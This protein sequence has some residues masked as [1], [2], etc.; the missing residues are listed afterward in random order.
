MKKNK[1]AA[2]IGCGIS[3]ITTAYILQKQGWEI[4]IIAKDDP[5]TSSLKPEFSSLYP[6][7]SIVPH[8]VFS[9]KIF[10]LFKD[11]LDHFQ[12]LYEQEFPGVQIHE[13]FE[14]FAEENIS[15]PDY[16][17][18]LKNLHTC[19]EFS[20]HFHPQHPDIPIQSGWKFDCFFAD[21]TLYFP[22]LIDLV[23]SKGVE[24]ELRELKAKDL[25]DLPYDIIINCSELGSI[26]L[27]EEKHD[28]IY[29]GHIL[30]IYDTPPLTDPAGKNVSYN[31][32]PGREVYAS[33]SGILQDVYLYPRRDGWVLGGS[34]QRGR[35]DEKGNWIGEETK[36]PFS[37]IDSIKVPAQIL[38]IHSDI[39]WNSFG[40][41]LRD[42]PKVKAKMGYRYIRKEENGLRLETEEMGDKLVVH[43]YGHGGAGVTLSWGC[44][45]KAAQL[46]DQYT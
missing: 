29:R 31:F 8:S 10:S 44:A 30:Q 13:H 22:A 15:L 33:E 40:I 27:F 41:S 45:L 37:I 12:L 9:D 21:W 35:L 4:T 20:D 28:L 1:K 3:G 25:P 39:I 42:H 17:P 32:S 26:G 24:F 34:R 6:A 2:I 14:L 18:L 23:F 36:S 43:N 7:A 19:D 11:S 16:A 5:R 38:Q 46:L